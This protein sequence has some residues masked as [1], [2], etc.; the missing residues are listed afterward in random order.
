[1]Y[2]LAHQATDWF[3]QRKEVHAL[4]LKGPDGYAQDFVISMMVPNQNSVVFY[5]KTT[6]WSCLS[7]TSCSHV[8]S[9]TS[10]CFG[11]YYHSQFRE[12]LATLSRRFVLQLFF[13][14]YWVWSILLPIGSE[15]QASMMVG[16]FPIVASCSQ[17]APP[18]CQSP[19]GWPSR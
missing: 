4:I 6:I 3:V 5:C 18:L 12:N 15:S 7:G 2:T 14:T 8:C 13:Q 10:S 9:R 17:V 16:T 11:A 19:M 1:M